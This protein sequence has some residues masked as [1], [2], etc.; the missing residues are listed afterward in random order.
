MKVLH[1]LK[2]ST[3]ATWALRQL[4]ELVKLGI[5]VHVA[6]P[7]GPL[8][9]SYQEFGITTHI[10]QTGFEV[11]NIW[12]NI[13][14]FRAFKKLVNEIKPDIIHS[15][16]VA[17][18]L[19]MRLAL[20]KNHPIKRIFHVP[21]PL[22][23]EHPFFRWAELATAGTS[24]YWMASCRWTALAYQRFGIDKD[25]IGLAY[26]GVDLNQFQV[27]LTANLHQELNLP[28][29][30]Q[31]IGNVAYFYAPKKLLGQKRG[32]KGHED[33]IDAIDIA[34]KTHPN[35]VGVFVGGPWDGCQD[36]MDQVIDYA[37]NK[38]HGRYHFLG[39]RR[40]IQNLYGDFTLAVHP[41][42]SE[43]VGG[44]VESM[45]C[46]CPTIASDIGG[47]PDLVMPEKTGWLA[48]SKSPELLAKK[49]TLALDDEDSRQRYAKAGRELATEMFDVRNNA[50]D[51]HRYYQKLQAT[52]KLGVECA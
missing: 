28:Q 8:V 25:R 35:I 6:L 33:L 30:S 20:G 45:F 51:I 13:A 16:F 14:R 48:P 40:D 18:T 3:G 31:I 49:I 24:D 1:L 39:L 46:Q 36:Y 42:H 38:H 26:Y 22:H 23:L 7:D 41:S 32:L 4:R 15:H 52:G 2:T 43:N 19:T 29:D 47:F 21:G 44:A 17:T 34:S 27:G 12:R 10:L 9:K 37:K 50:A 5:D 11:K